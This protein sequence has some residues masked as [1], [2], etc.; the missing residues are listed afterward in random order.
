MIF[1]WQ[2]RIFFQIV[3]LVMLS[4]FFI[5]RKLFKIKRVKLKKNEPRLIIFSELSCFL[6][7]L[8]NTKDKGSL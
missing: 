5:A 4:K 8:K 2:N 7:H 6:F 3:N 1:T